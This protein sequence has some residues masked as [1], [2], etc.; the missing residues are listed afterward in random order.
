MLM[1]CCT[2]VML[3]MLLA[4]SAAH[5][6]P[7]GCSAQ[8]QALLQAYSVRMQQALFAG[9]LVLYGQLAQNAEAEI[10]PAC[11]AALAKAQ[12]QQQQPQCSAQ[13]QQLLAQYGTAMLQSL[14]TGDIQRYLLLAQEMS[15]A[16]SPQ[17]QALLARSQQNYPR[18]GA[19]A[20]GRPRAPGSVIDHGGGVYSVPGGATCGPSGCI[21][22]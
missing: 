12:Q 7:Q 10:S 3:T 2:T 16:V 22:H 13:E 19:S 11:L 5:A 20:G 15:G 21:S 6:Q 1:R 18:P 4:V 17:C 14:E 9:N 8:D